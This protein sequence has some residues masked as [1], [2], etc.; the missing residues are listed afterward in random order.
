M[1]SRRPSDSSSIVQFE[2]QFVRPKEGRTL[3]V[4]SQVYA[5]KEDRRLRYKDVVGADMSNGPGV[6]W[7][8]DLEEPVSE[9]IDTFDHIEC[10]SVLEHSKRPWLIAAN[11]EKLLNVGG[12]IFVSVPFCWRLHSYPDDL[13]RMSPVAVRSIFANINWKKIALCEVVLRSEEDKISM[14]KVNDFPYLART[15]TAGFGIK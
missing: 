12:T 10:M 1:K 8:V 7:L 6:D 4:G 11:L 2:K 15:E 13:W 14:Y 9:D 3:I 5:D